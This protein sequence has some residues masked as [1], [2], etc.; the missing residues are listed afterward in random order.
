MLVI[1]RSRK[2]RNQTYQMRILSS[3]S[4]RCCQHAVKKEKENVDHQTRENPR[5]EKHIPIKTI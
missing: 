3:M 2:K 4:I 5:E 1:V